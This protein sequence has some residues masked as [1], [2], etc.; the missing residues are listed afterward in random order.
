MSFLLFFSFLVAE[1]TNITRYNQ[2][3]AIEYYQNGEYLSAIK[4]FQG[5]LEKKKINKGKVYYNIG[6]CYYK[7][8]QK[9]TE[10]SLKEIYLSL[11]ILNYEKALKYQPASTTILSNLKI[12]VDSLKNSEHYAVNEQNVILR[13]L[14]FFYYFSFELQLLLLIG[15][16]ILISLS[17]VLAFILKDKIRD[18]KSGFLFILILSLFY[19]FFTIQFTVR[20]K[21]WNYNIYA[22]V[23]TNKTILKSEPI[24]KS[25]DIVTLPAGMKIKILRKENDWYRV[26]YANE[27]IGW[28]EKKKIFLIH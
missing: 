1:K 24:K 13:L 5:I 7:I 6:N 2:S 12:A 3:I 10:N 8:Y 14:F 15:S 23:K 11:S 4:V 21:N 22:I 19:A 20:S 17:I 28:V 27:A 16:L 26:S 18:K 25:N 9:E